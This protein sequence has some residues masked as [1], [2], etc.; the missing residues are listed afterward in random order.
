MS[1]QDPDAKEFASFLR[2]AVVPTLFLKGLILFFGINYSNNPGEG[3]GYGLAAVCAI[4][5]V[6]ALVFI[7]KQTRKS[8]S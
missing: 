7:W 4:S 6:S 3:Y 2:I 1:Q 5:V 8:G